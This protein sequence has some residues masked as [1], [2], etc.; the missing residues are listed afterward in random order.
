[1][2]ATGLVKK[3]GDFFDVVGNGGTSI[4]GEL[5]GGI[6]GDFL[7]GTTAIVLSYKQKR[8]EKNVLALFEQLNKREKEL[9]ERLSRLEKTDK[10]LSTFELVMDYVADEPQVDKIQFMANGLLE[11]SKH[12]EVKDDFVLLYYDTLRDLRMVDIRVL[13]FY[14]VEDNPDLKSVR[15]YDEMLYQL[16]ISEDQYRAV[17]EKLDRMGLLS[18]K[19]EQEMNKLADSV[20][21]ILDYLGKASQGKNARL[22]AKKLSK[23]DRYTTSKFGREFVRFFLEKV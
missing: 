19:R 18:T 13:R 11:L 1:M 10:F 8:F 12:D 23:R 22:S 6:I 15:S 17:Q 20:N 5:A 4:I 21:G 14:Y 3:I 7:P 2:K 16:G 9:E